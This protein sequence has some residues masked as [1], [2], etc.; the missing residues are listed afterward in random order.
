MSEKISLENTGAQG[1]QVIHFET[2]QKKS[3]TGQNRAL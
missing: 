2:G 1:Y 3:K